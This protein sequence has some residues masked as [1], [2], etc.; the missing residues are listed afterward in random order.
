MCGASG[1][2]VRETECRA[3]GGKVC[4]YEISWV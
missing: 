4:R 2:R 3:K 1:V